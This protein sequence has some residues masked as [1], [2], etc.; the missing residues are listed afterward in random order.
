MSGVPL[1]V[2]GRFACPAGWSGH[3]AGRPSMVLSSIL[4]EPQGTR[5]GCPASGW[6]G[7][8]G[9]NVAR[10]RMRKGWQRG[11]E[12]AAGAAEWIHSAEGGRPSPPFCFLPVS[13]AE[14]RLVSLLRF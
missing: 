9:W 2:F 11:E 8:E 1:L 5:G 12:R 3:S 10:V 6:S 14:R 7:W 4:G 13:V